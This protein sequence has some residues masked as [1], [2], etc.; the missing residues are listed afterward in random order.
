MQLKEHKRDLHTFD[1][2]VHYP[3]ALFSFFLSTIVENTLSIAVM[4]ESNENII[5]KQVDTMFQMI[6]LE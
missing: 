4:A 3:V 6:P 2:A 5:Q 1:S